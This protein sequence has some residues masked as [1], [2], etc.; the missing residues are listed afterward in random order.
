VWTGAQAKER[1]LVDVLGSFEDAVKIAANAAGVQDDYRVRF[2][3]Q[4]T[5][6]FFEQLVEQFDEEE[7]QAEAMKKQLGEHYY[8]YQQWKNVKSYEGIQARMPFEMKIN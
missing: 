4:Y 8:L 5:P 6:G 2:F 3:P 7:A 1:G